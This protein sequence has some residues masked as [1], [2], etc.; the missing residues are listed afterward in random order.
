M[1]FLE[2]RRKARERAEA[3]EAERARAIL[4]AG[5]PV[6]AAAP[7]ELTAPPDVAGP[8]RVAAPPDLAEPA[9]SAEAL[10]PARR[11]FPA[12]GSEEARR[13]EEELTRRVAGLPH[14]P[15]KRFVTWRPDGDPAP[16]ADAAA[17]PDPEGAGG[18]GA[19]G[20]PRGPGAAGRSAAPADPLDEFFYDPR[21][22]GPDLGRFAPASAPERALPETAPRA[23]YLTFHLSGEFYGIEIERVREVLRPPP[24]TE[25]PRAPTGVLGV[26]TVRGE[27]VTV[28]DPRRRLGLPAGAAADG[29]RIVIV[30]DGEG[31]CGVL[32]D[33]MSSVVRLP[34][35]SIEPCPQGLG[36]QGADCLAGIGRDRDRLFTV[37]DLGALL[38]PPRRAGEGRG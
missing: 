21:E 38:R 24:V 32:V 7:P 1:D 20:P 33:A 13:I 10:G 6:A 25:V 30:D 19:G 17:D 2:I 14:A 23:E 3:R 4:P 18:G 12:P 26:V 8:P 16:E 28:L 27:V 11:P 35:G 22:P 9:R 36:V 31:V 34:A 5:S 29:G 37:L 15:D